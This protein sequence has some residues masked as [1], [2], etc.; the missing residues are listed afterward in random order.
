VAATSLAV[1]VLKE[2]F[3]SALAAKGVT[4]SVIS[5]EVKAAVTLDGL[6]GSAGEKEAGLTFSTTIRP[7]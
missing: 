5:Y 7:P 3:I 6:A 4:A 1:V 2:T